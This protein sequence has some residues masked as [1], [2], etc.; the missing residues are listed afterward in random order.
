MMKKISDYLFLRSIHVCPTWCCFTFDNK[1]RTYFHDPG[2]MLSKY[3]K[4]GNFVLD[5]G[6][7]QGYFTIPMAGMVGDS[8][9]VIAIDVQEK[10]LQV[11][12]TKAKKHK[13]DHRILPQV[14]EPDKLEIEYLADFALAF[15]MVHEVPHQKSFLKSVYDSLKQDKFLFVAEPK[16]HVTGKMFEKT[17]SIAQQEGFVIDDRPKVAFSRAVLLKKK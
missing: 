3:V 4:P 9:K 10:M 11:L 8:G 13:L 2:K 6:P 5:I 12:M 16:F 7:G 17:V 1:L 15:W 14:A